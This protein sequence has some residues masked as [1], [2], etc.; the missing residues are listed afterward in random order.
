ME[1]RNFKLCK[2]VVYGV[3]GQNVRFR[4]VGFLGD[5]DDHIDSTGEWL[6]VKKPRLW[7]VPRFH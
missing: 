4:N 5:I 2:A 7:N 1:Q 6:N 3:A